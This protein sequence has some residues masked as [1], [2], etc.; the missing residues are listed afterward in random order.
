MRP[1]QRPGHA[2]V[3]STKAAGILMIASPFLWFA[4]A[5]AFIGQVGR[6]YDPGDPIT[7]LAGLEGQRGA[8]AAQSLLFFAGTQVLVIG[9]LLLAARL[10]RTRARS[11]AAA[12]AIASAAV[13]LS[14]AFTLVVRL[15]APE[16]VRSAA[17]VP[18]ILMSLHFGPLGVA[19]TGLTLVTVAV[20]GVALVQSRLAKVSGAVLAAMCVLVLFATLTGGPLPPVVVYP[21]AA[22]M[23]ARV[24]FVPSS[25]GTEDGRRAA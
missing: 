19:I 4:G 15:A 5:V 12:G 2:P 22:L 25:D 11:L 20:F 18:E 14:S 21:I 1:G 8:W 3:M 23:G 16:G 7:R 6:F 13:A 9:L 17:D 24:L 10:R